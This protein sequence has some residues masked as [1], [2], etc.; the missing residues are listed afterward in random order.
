[1]AALLFFDVVDNRLFAAG[2][3]VDKEIN[4][5]LKFDIPLHVT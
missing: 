2:L 4:G 3:Y 1:M 5:A